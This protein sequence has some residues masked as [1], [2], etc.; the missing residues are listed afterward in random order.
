MTT[1][2]ETQNDHNCP[3]IKADTNRKIRKGTNSLRGSFVGN[4][5]LVQ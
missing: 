3:G 4:P 2:K 1:E 5:R